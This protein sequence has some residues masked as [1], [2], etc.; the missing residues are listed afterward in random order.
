[1]DLVMKVDSNR[2]VRDTNT[3]TSNRVWSLHATCIPCNPLELEHGPRP[4]PNEVQAISITST[5][6][7]GC[8]YWTDTVLRSEDE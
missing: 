4:D 2:V 7:S 1:M 3:S 5:S 8:W 6:T